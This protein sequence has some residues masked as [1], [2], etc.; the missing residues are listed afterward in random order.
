MSVLTATTTTQTKGGIKS[1]HC[2]IYLSSSSPV[3]CYAS[4]AADEQMHV[5]SLCNN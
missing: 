1:C 2:V 3:Q 4:L 5:K